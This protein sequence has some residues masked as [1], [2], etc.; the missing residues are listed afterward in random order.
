M[1]KIY[2]KPEI[3]AVQEKP[4]CSSICGWFTTCGEQVSYNK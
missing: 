3:K 2:R 4:A 1:K